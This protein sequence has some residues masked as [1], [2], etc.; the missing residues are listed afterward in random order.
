MGTG[1]EASLWDLDVVSQERGCLGTGR[2]VPVRSARSR[3][4]E[5]SVALYTCNYLLFGNSKVQGPLG[6]P[7]ASSKGNTE[8]YASGN[9]LLSK[10][11]KF[12][13]NVCFAFPM[14]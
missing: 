7:L 5:A 11:G 4:T 2:A 12:D 1:Q 14:N 8:K 9:K 6:A 13:G 10:T 3:V